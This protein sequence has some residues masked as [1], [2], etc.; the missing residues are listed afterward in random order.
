MNNRGLFNQI[1][2]VLVLAIALGTVFLLYFVWVLTAPIVVD[3]TGMAT[4]SIV[5]ATNN[6]PD[7]NLTFASQ[8]SFPIA[9][10][11][12]NH[13][14]W[15]G[16]FVLIALLMGF[17]MIAFYVRTYP[18]L[19]WVWIL[20]ILIMVFIGILLSVSY[21]NLKESS[22][23]LN[24][25][26]SNWETDNFILSYLPHLITGFGLLGGIILFMLATKDPEAEA[27]GFV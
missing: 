19:A 24:N 6:Q 1:L 16:F 21:T 23:Y 25:V 10:R 9:E 26:Y 7:G 22:S 15:I 8:N 3:L 2:I 11:S 14:E 12:A 20:V 17:L 13:L 27:G 18:F 4:Q 5:N